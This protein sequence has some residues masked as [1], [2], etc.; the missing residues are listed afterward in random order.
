[1]RY[2][3]ILP[4]L[5]LL[6]TIEETVRL[7]FAAPGQMASHFNFAGLPDRFVPKAAFFA[8]QI[9]TEVIV[10]ALAV[11]F[12]IAL[13][14]LPVEFIH[15]GSRKF[16]LSPSQRAAVTRR[17]GSFVDGL[18]S[19]ILLLILTGFELAVSANLRTPIV[20]NAGLM[21]AAVAGMIL[22]TLLM[23]VGLML[24]LRFDSPPES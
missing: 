5:I 12:R 19:V 23:L 3:R 1:M 17:I 8:F 24:S 7:W 15:V 21:G 20:F 10:I 11:V 18:F 2:T 22:L 13:V 4:G 6:I 14:I 16:R 9:Q